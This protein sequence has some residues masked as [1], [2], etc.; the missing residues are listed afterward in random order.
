VGAAGLGV[1][2]AGLRNL[3]YSAAAEL[4]PDGVHVTTVTIRGI[5]KAG[6]AFDPEL[7]AEHYWRLHQQG[8]AEWEPEFVLSR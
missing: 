4:A 1:A 6:T 5:L 3:A 2:K 8:R 7:I